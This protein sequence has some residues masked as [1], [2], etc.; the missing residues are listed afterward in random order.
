VV[1]VA[2]EVLVLCCDAMW[3]GSSAAGV[4]KNCAVVSIALVC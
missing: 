2:W 4:T 1:I 3:A